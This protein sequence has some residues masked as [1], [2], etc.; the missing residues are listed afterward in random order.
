MQIALRRIGESTWAG[1]DTTLAASVTGTS[2]YSVS[3]ETGDEQ[4]AASDPLY[5]E[6]PYRVTITSTGTATDLTRPNVK[7]IYRIEAVVQLA[8]RKL[9]PVPAGWTSLET[10]AVYQW[11]NLNVYAQ[12]PM[13]IEGP[14]TLNGKVYLCTEYPTNA[15]YKRR[16][17]QDLNAMRLD[18]LPD[19]RPFKGPLT[20]VNSRQDAATLTSLQNDLG[21]TTIN[22]TSTG[23]SAPVT[24]PTSVATYK[25]YPGGQAYTPP[26]LQT[27]YG[28]TLINLTVVPDPKTNPLG[29]LRSTGELT[30]GNNVNITG[31]IVAESSSADLRISGQQVTL[32][33][34]TCPLWMAQ[35]SPGNCRCSSCAAT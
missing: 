2:S 10:P 6:Y 4:L 3:F 12:V 14:A 32:A 24:C 7:S 1:V 30:I 26:V 28:S 16:Y 9:Y 34:P 15:T 13:R 27:K 29:L 8:R 33:A 25:L 21:L 20:L 31:T 23:T 35:A 11:A 18:G 17:L 5:G 22:S 19:H